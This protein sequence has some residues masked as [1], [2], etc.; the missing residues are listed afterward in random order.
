MKFKR[1]FLIVLDSLGVGGS[2]DAQNYGDKD[3]NTLARNKELSDFYE[4]TVSLGADPII[5]S[6][7]LTGQI[8]SYLNKDELK[9][10]EIF[11][12]PTMLSD[13]LNSVTIFSNSCC[14]FSF[15]PAIAI[16]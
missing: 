8:L 14:I 16:T 1:I 11:L 15:L 10:T 9:I 4:E 7:Y 6:N 13:L 2:I 12:T 5:T 3:A